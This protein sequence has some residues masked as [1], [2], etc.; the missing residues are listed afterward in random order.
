MRALLILFVI[1]T[2]H[3]VHAQNQFGNEWIDP[4]KQYVKIKVAEDGIYRL[5]FENLVASGLING[6]TKGQDFQLFNYG[7][8][9]PIFISDNNFGSGDYVEFYGQRNTIGLDSTLYDNWVDD[10]FNPYY[11][12]VTDTNAYFL[13]LNS[14]NNNL[15]YAQ[16]NP[17]FNANVTTIPYYLH[18]ELKIFSNS[19]YKKLES[20]KIRES[21]FEPSEGFGSILRKKSSENIATSKV[22]SN[23]PTPKLSFRTG[24]NNLYTTSEVKF[25][26]M[27]LAYDT[28]KQNATTQFSFDIP[29]NEIKGTNTLEISSVYGTDDQHRIAYI[30]LLYPRD[31]DFNNASFTKFILPKSDQRRKANIINIKNPNSG[32]VL[33]DHLNKI[34]YNTSASGGILTIITNPIL[35]QTEYVLASEVDGIKKVENLSLFT[36]NKF[37]DVGQDYII[38]T[39]SALYESGENYV[40]Q[41][42]DYR[43]SADGGNHI[44]SV[45][46]IQDVYDNFGYGIDRHFVS[47]KNMSGYLSKHWNKAKFLFIIGKGVEYPFMRSEADVI[48]N[49][50]RVFF[51]PTF[52]YAGSDVMLTSTRNSIISHFALGRLAARNP[53]DIEIYLNKVKQYEAA[54]KL[55]QTVDEKFWQKRVLHLGGGKTDSEQLQIIAGLETMGKIIS[56]TIWGLEVNPYYKNSNAAVSFAV[57]EEIKNL[58][59]SGVSIINFFGHSATTSWDFSLQNP[60]DYDNYGKYPFINS[61]GCYSGNL[62]SSSK[63]ISEAFVLEKDKGSIAFFAST[64]TAFI[65]DLTRYGKNFYTYLNGKLRYHSFGEVIQQ[66]Q[67]DSTFV[68]DSDKNLYAQLTYHGDPAIKPY[69][70]YGVD[71]T[72][73]AS[74]VKTEPVSI[75]I[76]DNDVTL[77]VDI[78]NLG[79]HTTDS[80]DL[81]FYHFLP[82]GLP[83]DTISL[84]IPPVA[85]RQALKV[86]ITTLGQASL[87][88][89]TIKGYIDYNG[90]LTE[91]PS[92]E[93]EQNNT[94][95]VNAQD[96]YDF[97]VRDNFAQIVY[98]PDFAMINTSEHFILKASTITVPLLNSKYVFEIDTTRYFNSPIKERGTV[99]SQG[100]VIT[101]KPNLNLVDGRVF[102]WRVSPEVESGTEYKWSEASFAYLPQEAEGWNQSHYFQFAQNKFQNVLY[103]DS[104]TY[105]KFYFDYDKY[106]LKV[107]NKLYDVNDFPLYVRNNVTIGSFRKVWEYFDGGLVFAVLDKKIGEFRNPVGGKYGSIPPPGSDGSAGFAFSTKTSV[108]R[109][110]IIDFLDSIFQE[111]R[112]VTVMSVIGKRDTDLKIADWENDK[113]LYGTTLF[114]KFSEIGANKFELF[115]TVGSMPY[116]CTIERDILGKYNNIAEEIAYTIDDIIEVSHGVNAISLTN[117]SINSPIIGPVEKWNDLKFKINEIDDPNEVSIANIYHFMDQNNSTKIDSN[118]ISNKSL[119]YLNQNGIDKIQLENFAIDS[120]TRSMAQLQYWRIS[121]IHLPDAAISYVSSQ[122]SF[123]Q[124][125]IQQ[126]ETFTLNY[127]VTNTNFTAM[128]SILVKYTYFGNDNQPKVNYKR[129]KNLSPGEK[130]QDKISFIIGVSSTTGIRVEVEIN[131]NSDQPELYA[132]NNFLSIQLNVAKD[133]TNPLLDVYFDGVRIMD[134]DIVSPK[135]KILITLQ[136]E[137]TFLPVT[138]PKLFEL[139]LDTGRNQFLTIPIPSNL[140]SFKPA[141]A[142][143]GKA[144]LTY[145]PSLKEGEYTLLVQAKD[146]TGNASGVNPKSINFRVI[147]K[148]SISNVL[149]YPN[150]FSTSTQFIF[151]LTGEQMPESM[152]ITIMTLSGKVVREI[153]K[154]ELGPL[155]IGQ[156]RTEFKWDGTDQF[157]SKLANG[158]YLYKVNVRKNNNETY[159]SFG[160]KNIDNLFKDGF[161]KLVILR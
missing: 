47:V 116:F 147:E 106:L 72:F 56:D 23:G 76:N 84:R 13:T 111:N 142:L 118:I 45:I 93:A 98:P 133:D 3:D 107:R 113:N 39:H 78:V 134:G 22:Y 43:R 10:L 41:F 108:D 75:G 103:D 27:E 121:H 59:E 18:N 7:N 95:I 9:Q 33:Y 117:G 5:Y 110:K 42:A 140:V 100:G 26:G 67:I 57:N 135:P 159:D 14:D 148:Q 120:L 44:V 1:L 86:P 71:Y 74:T 69:L 2:L 90:K 29:F 19:F 16:V 104:L 99:E 24:Q 155:K 48:N 129:L 79:S 28:I 144:E 53:E 49:L 124:S 85:N 131:P 30:S 138:D 38:L 34:R 66:L 146:A 65:G 112:V 4:S 127:E 73:D 101:Y 157:G 64:S 68:S 77:N 51:I 137:N 58:F 158:V 21:F 123:T 12:V 141:T 32:V 132:F 46:D 125:N 160:N 145:S 52:G 89:N 25:N 152:T 115:K 88:K 6:D 60:R 35:E 114:E 150:P 97:F 102:Y 126:G 63:G 151:T 161:G 87:G 50:N 82:N 119:L 17:D 156:N 109:K 143:D 55:P 149:N 83:A 37:E 8:E 130:I 62:H 139:K 11:S 122:P 96:G 36:P 54:F 136:D 105:R 20:S 154:E 70:P 15:R 61:F 92:P 80:L 128:D 91:I 153:T 31:W 40:D 81:I 94:L